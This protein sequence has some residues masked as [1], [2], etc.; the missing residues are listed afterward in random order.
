MNMRVW[1]LCACV[2][3]S[4]AS[5]KLAVSEISLRARHR[6]REEHRVLYMS[7]IEVHRYQPRRREKLLRL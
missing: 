3:S 6:L 5:Q 7:S 4:D 1:L 2:H